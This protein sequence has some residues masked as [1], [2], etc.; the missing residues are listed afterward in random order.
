MKAFPHHYAVAARGGPS[1]DVSLTSAGLAPLASAPPL[2][3]GGRGDLWSPETLLV[4]AVADCFLLTFRAIARARNL[5]WTALEVEVTG[6]LDRVEG[7]S[8]FTRFDT[9]ARLQLA[10]GTDREQAE[11]ALHK[12]ESGCLISN[13]LSGDKHLRTQVDSPA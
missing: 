8:R 13:S 10:A 7:N 12:A 2:E 1:D 11:L 9:S 3:F 5:E 4:A 6:T